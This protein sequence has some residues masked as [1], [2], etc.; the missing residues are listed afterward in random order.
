MEKELR[1]K[2]PKSAMALKWQLIEI[3]QSM[4][5]WRLS[6]VCVYLAGEK[7]NHFCPM[8]L[9]YALCRSIRSQ[10]FLKIGVLKNFVNSTGKHSCWCL[11]LIKALQACNI[12]NPNLGGLF[13][14]LFWEGGGVKLPP[15]LKLVRITLETSNL[16]RKYTPICS[17]R[18]YTF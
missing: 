12:I 13:R 11:F 17:F 7:L 18:K 2:L 6:M 15:Y 8:F 1:S 4:R 10:I 14:G 5:L 16:A 3:L 9:F